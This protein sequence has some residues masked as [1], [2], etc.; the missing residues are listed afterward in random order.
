MKNIELLPGLLYVKV[1]KTHGESEY[2]YTGD[3]KQSPHRGEVLQVA[4]GESTWKD[5]GSTR[6][7][8][9]DAS[10][11]FNKGDYVVW[12]KNLEKATFENDEYAVVHIKNVLA[13]IAQ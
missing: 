13:K 1:D 9:A 12:K 8:K 6:S 5:E 10:K 3:Y 11:F 4:E 2:L 7:Q